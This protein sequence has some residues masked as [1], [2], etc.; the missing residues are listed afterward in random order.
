[1]L[2][3]I[4]AG[5]AIAK[6]GVK[7]LK[8]KKRKKEDEK[9][10]KEYRARDAKE[11]RQLKKLDDI[12]REE[13]KKEMA[14]PEYKRQRKRDLDATALRMFRR[15]KEFPEGARNVKEAREISRQLENELKKETGPTYSPIPPSP[16]KKGG[17][18]KAKK[19]TTRK[20]RGDSIARKGKTKGRMI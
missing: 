17:I 9:L 20:F 14:T 8:N 4:R 18:V 19:K 3:I 10:I 7:K 16:M 5:M 2:P 6:T 15:S 1:M 13:V 11:A 12:S